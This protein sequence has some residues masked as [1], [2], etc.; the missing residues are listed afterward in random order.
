M[1][2]SA[3]AATLS[4]CVDGAARLL[5]PFMPFLAEEFYQRLHYLGMAGVGP[6]D[7]TAPPVSVG[8]APFPLGPAEYST[9]QS[10]LQEVSSIHGKAGD[11]ARG[12]QVSLAD[13][14]DSKSEARFSALLLVVGV[15]RS[16]SDTRSRILGANTGPAPSY[17]RRILLVAQSQNLSD[18]LEEHRHELEF[19]LRLRVDT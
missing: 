1:K 5:Q 4:V 9:E 18:L 3:H 15:A 10:L 8:V 6:G 14:R 13:Y 12:F 16:L 7:A 2:S 17:A 19:L 11:A